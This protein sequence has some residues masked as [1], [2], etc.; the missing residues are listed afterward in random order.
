MAI[1]KLKG[2]KVGVRTITALVYAI[3]SHCTGTHPDTSAMAST[4]TAKPK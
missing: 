4:A 3:A 1:K 2:N